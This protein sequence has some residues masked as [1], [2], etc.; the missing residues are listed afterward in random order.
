MAAMIKA[1]HDEN[2]PP[3]ADGAYLWFKG[4]INQN[5]CA[6]VFIV[7]DGLIVAERNNGKWTNLDPH[8]T[9]REDNGDI[10]IE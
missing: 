10:I 4:D 8:Y 9:V 2:K 5:P 6:N 3:P 1:W 7:K